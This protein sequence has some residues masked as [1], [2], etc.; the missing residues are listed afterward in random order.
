VCIKKRTAGP[1]DR[2]LK[3]F[4]CFW[5]I[6]GSR[7]FTCFL[8]FTMHGGKSATKSATL[9]ET[10]PGLCRKVG[11]MEFG[12]NRAIHKKRK[13]LA[14]IGEPKQ[15]RM[16]GRWM[17]FRTGCYIMTSA[18]NR[19]IILSLTTTIYPRYPTTI[20]HRIRI[21][22]LGSWQHIIAT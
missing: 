20:D 8:A 21:D 22:D 5:K 9:S 17:N 7:K 2:H 18:V 15:C 10:C 6:S 19:P 4:F 16:K 14:Y 11:I 13:T 12:L 3:H 1:S